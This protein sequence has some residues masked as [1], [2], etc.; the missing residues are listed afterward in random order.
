MTSQILFQNTFILR[1]P[2]VVILADIMKI[3]TMF[4]IKIFQDWKS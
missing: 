3:V 2:R 4:V 1:R